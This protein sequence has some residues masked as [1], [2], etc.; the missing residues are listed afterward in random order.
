LHALLPYTGK[1]IDATTKWLADQTTKAV[2]RTTNHACP[3]S[4]QRQLAI[5]HLRRAE[6]RQ[7]A[8][9]YIQNHNPR[10]RQKNP[11]QRRDQ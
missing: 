4:V 3:A 11:L 5:V 6:I 1:D 8:D 9:T 2:H 7:R 10:R